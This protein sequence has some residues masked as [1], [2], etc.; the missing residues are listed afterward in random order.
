MNDDLQRFWETD[1]D[2]IFALGDSDFM[3]I[4]MISFY[5]FLFLKPP[6]SLVIIVNGTKTVHKI[7]GESNRKPSPINF[8]LLLKHKEQSA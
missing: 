1:K 8:T 7:K 6:N 2:P 4:S 3:F 5:Y